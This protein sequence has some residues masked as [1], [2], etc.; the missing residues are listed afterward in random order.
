MLQIWFYMFSSCLSASFVDID[1]QEIDP[2]FSCNQK[3]PCKFREQLCRIYLHVL[4][5]RRL[6]FRYLLPLGNNLM[7]AYL[8]RRRTVKN[9]LHRLS[10]LCLRSCMHQRS[11]RGGGGRGATAPPPIMLFR[12]FVDTFGNL[13][14]HVNRQACHLYRQS[15]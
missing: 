11:Q 1:V 14:V 3:K 8:L 13:S 10:T 9:L 4:S 7:Q 2:K 6:S 15:I 12:S 5:K